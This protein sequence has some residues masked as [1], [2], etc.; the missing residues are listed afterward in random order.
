MSD[1]TS[2]SETGATPGIEAYTGLSIEE[3]R[4][5]FSRNV[6]VSGFFSDPVGYFTT[7]EPDYPQ[8]MEKIKARGGLHLAVMGGI[9]PVL[10]Q[11]AVARPELT[12]MVDVNTRA[13]DEVLEGRL[14]PLEDSESGDDYWDTVSTYY[15]DEIAKKHPERLELFN[16]YHGPGTWSDKAHFANVR[17]AFKRGKIKIMSGDIITNGLNVVREIAQNSNVPVRLVYVSNIFEY[18]ENSQR[19]F[20][21]RLQEGMTEG[22][23]DKEGQL[24][25]NVFTG[26]DIKT[27]VMGIKDYLNAPP[28]KLTF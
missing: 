10:G 28:R 20:Q 1:G 7:N 6:P 11:I 21:I 4:Q 2:L 15:K 19:A 12:V 26:R 24:I 13:V 25:E 16:Y 3:F 18:P 17:D 9:D 5:R 8:S 23:I 27:E 14:K 22:W